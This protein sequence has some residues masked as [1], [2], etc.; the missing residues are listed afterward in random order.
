MRVGKKNGNASSSGSGPISISEAME[1]MKTAYKC[2]PEPP[3][4]SQDYALWAKTACEAAVSDYIPFS[5][6]C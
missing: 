5:G 6:C 4:E 3:A 2:E 1:A